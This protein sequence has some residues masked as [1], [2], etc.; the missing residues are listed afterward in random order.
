MTREEAFSKENEG[1]QLTHRFFDKCE[2]VMVKDGIYFLEDEITQT[3]EEFWF[4][5]TNEAWDIDW[6]L[7]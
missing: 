2:F 5:R 7:K 4:S 1:L 3:A 6:D